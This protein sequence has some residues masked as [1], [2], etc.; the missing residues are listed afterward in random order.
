MSDHDPTIV[1]EPVIDLRSVSLSQNVKLALTDLFQGLI[2]WRLGWKLALLDIKLRYRGSILGP[3]WITII[4][5]A[6]ISTIGILYAYLL[7]LDLQHYFTYVAISVVLWTYVNGMV[8]DSCLIFTSSSQLILSQRLSYSIYVWRNVF[9]NILILLHN[10][11]VI[12]VV[13][14][15]FRIVPYTLY[16]LL[17]A[18]I[19]WLVNSLALGIIFGILGT[20]FKD[21]PPIVAGVMQSLF[22]I[23]PIIWK[24]SSLHFNSNY[25]LLNPLYPLFEIVRSPILGEHVS[26]SIWIAAIGYSLF[27]WIAALFI[28]SKTRF[29]IPYWM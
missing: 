21:I 5:G 28:F 26:A 11:L 10:L 25:V 14:T 13:F 15:I 7:H 9:C 16:F 20:R 27:L 22:F 19:L 29:R 12:I 4:M 2:Q 17:P 6:K 8:N 24:V 1:K 3:F 18:A 23:T